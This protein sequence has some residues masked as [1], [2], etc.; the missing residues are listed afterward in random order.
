MA[1]DVMRLLMTNANRDDVSKVTVDVHERV[2]AFLNNR[3]RRD[4]THLEEVYNVSISV[5]A[6]TGVGPEHLQ[7]HCTSDLGNEVKILAAA[8]S[9]SK[10]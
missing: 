2:A 1:I 7:F 10:A 3:K 4:I 8:G 6:M 9:K 5:N